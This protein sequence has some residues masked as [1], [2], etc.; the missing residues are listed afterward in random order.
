M[1]RRG[2]ISTSRSRSFGYMAPMLLAV[3]P[4]MQIRR[5]FLIFGTIPAKLAPSFESPRP[6][7][8]AID[9]APLRCGEPHLARAAVAGR[10]RCGFHA[11]AFGAVAAGAGDRR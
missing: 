4:S 3:G 10:R 11:M 5:R 7:H 1:R 8:A 6:I 2:L 9:E